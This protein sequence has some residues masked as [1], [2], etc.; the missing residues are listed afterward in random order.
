MRLLVALALALAGLVVVP[1][2]APAGTDREDRVVHVTTTEDSLVASVGWAAPGVVTFSVSGP[3]SATLLQL[4]DGYTLEELYAD[5]DRVLSGRSGPIRRIRRGATFLG[6]MPGGVG[7]AGA[8]FATDLVPGV[9]QLADLAHG[10]A[11]T[12]EVLDLAESRGQAP[13]TAGTVS[14]TPLGITMPRTMTPGGWMRVVNQGTQVSLM[15]VVRLKPGTTE[16]QVRAFFRTEG[17]SFRGR[18]TST[19][20]STLLLS[21]GQRYWWS[22]SLP[23]GPVAASSSWPREKDGAPQA[24]HGMWGMTALE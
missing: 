6:G 3:G 16:K 7:D 24:H 19:F 23:R 10:N 11:V 9:Y 4:H 17:R 15:E 21:P 22:Y 1:A 20:D 2:A 12:F 18:F 13:V 5:F 8:L 14:Y